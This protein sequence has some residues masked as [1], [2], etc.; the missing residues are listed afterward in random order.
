[1]TG[2]TFHQC[3]NIAAPRRTPP[4]RH[5]T[6]SANKVSFLAIELVRPG[7]GGGFASLAYHLRPD[8]QYD[9]LHIA[10]W[11][12]RQTA[13]VSITQMIAA[14]LLFRARLLPRIRIS[15]EQYQFSTTACFVFATPTRAGRRARLDIRFTLMTAEGLGLKGAEPHKLIAI[16]YNSCRQ[17]LTERFRQLGLLLTLSVRRSDSFGRCRIISAFLRL[18]RRTRR[19]ADDDARRKR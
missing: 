3:A 8:S 7:D 9:D 14:P 15:E 4:S 19:A 13:Y 6:P 2:M 11:R 5:R 16:I 10:V 17:V 1:M 18:F 12:R